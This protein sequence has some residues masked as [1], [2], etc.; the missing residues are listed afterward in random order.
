MT[1]Q[2][3]GGTLALRAVGAAMPPAAGAAAVPLTAGPGDVTAMAGAA[4]GAA[5][6][7]L[8][9][10]WHLSMPRIFQP[11]PV[12]NHAQLSPFAAKCLYYEG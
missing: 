1:N 2:V 5:L 7:R 12:G 6:V 10:D 3:C 8:T 11:D 9:V 4:A